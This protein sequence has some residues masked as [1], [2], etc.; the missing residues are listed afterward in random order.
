MRSQKSLSRLSGVTGLPNP[1][2]RRFAVVRFRSLAECLP[3][4]LP[5]EVGD[6]LVEVAAE[7][8]R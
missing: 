4:P 1:E 2:S 6:R 8:T 3:A 5:P 7:D